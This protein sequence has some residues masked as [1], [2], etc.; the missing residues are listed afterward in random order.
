MTLAGP[1]CK[2]VLVPGS[3]IGQEAAAHLSHDVDRNFDAN[4]CNDLPI[5]VHGHLSRGFHGDL[6]KPHAWRRRLLAGKNKRAN[7]PE[8]GGTAHLTDHLNLFDHLDRHLS[9]HL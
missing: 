4:F 7:R 3:C 2:G 6:I 1:P 5:N 9:Y 8:F